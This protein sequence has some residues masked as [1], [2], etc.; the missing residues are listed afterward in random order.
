MTGTAWP[1]LPRLRHSIAYGHATSHTLKLTFEAIYDLGFMQDA[2]WAHKA[3]GFRNDRD[4]PFAKPCLMIQV[5]N[6]MVRIANSNHLPAT[7]LPV[8]ESPTT[9]TT[10]ISVSDHH[11]RYK[12]PLHRMPRSNAG[13]VS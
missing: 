9:G 6:A 5:H 2:I 13:R 1:P 7:V 11:L 3:L 8:I 4:P 12:I 10:S